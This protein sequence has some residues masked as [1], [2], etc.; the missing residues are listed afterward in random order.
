VASP[1]IHRPDF[2]YAWQEYMPKGEGGENCNPARNLRWQNS[3]TN[4]SQ[5]EQYFPP[6]SI[7]P[8]DFSPLDITVQPDVYLE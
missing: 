1:R 6:Q 7:I 5:I 3:D 2:G 4:K 8:I